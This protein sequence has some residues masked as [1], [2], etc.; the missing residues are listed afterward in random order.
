MAAI[1]PP[2]TRHAFGLPDKN[3]TAVAEVQTVL[4]TLCNYTSGLDGLQE[5]PLSVLTYPPFASVYPNWMA[6]YLVE[7]ELQTNFY[8]PDLASRTEHPLSNRK[9]A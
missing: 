9:S 4:A 3:A 8:F 7:Q 5:V 2:L 1:A 6:L